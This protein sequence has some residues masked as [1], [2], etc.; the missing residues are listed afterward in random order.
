M[1]A[2]DVVDAS[3]PH[4]LRPTFSQTIHQQEGAG[5]SKR[6]HEFA[7]IGPGV[8][9][10]ARH[11]ELTSHVAGM[12]NRRRVEKFGG[13]LDFTR[14]AMDLIDDRVGIQCVHRIRVREDL[15]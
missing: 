4:V 12:Q 6:K 9:V 8:E 11:E 5:S 10:T 3:G 1:G 7:S 13:S 15:F 14:T 2:I